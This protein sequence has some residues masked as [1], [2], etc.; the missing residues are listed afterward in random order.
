MLDSLEADYKHDAEDEVED[1][2]SDDEELFKFSNLA[3]VLMGL[4]NDEPSDDEG[5]DGD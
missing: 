2:D 3:D 5:G 1:I 4:E